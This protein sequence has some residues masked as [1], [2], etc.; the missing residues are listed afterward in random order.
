MDSRSIPELRAWGALNRRREPDSH[1]VALSPAQARSLERLDRTRTLDFARG[2]ILYSVLTAIGAFVLSVR[3]GAP[4]LAILCAIGVGLLVTALG[5]T[6]RL[7]VTVSG[8]VVILT[9]L[10][11]VVALDVGFSGDASF[12]LQLFGLGLAVFVL[13]FEAPRLVRAVLT[14]VIAGMFVALQFLTSD[15]LVT[16]GLS[17]A[18]MHTVSLWNNLLTVSAVLVA[19]LMLQMRF[20]AAR[21]ILEGTA[22]YGELQASTDPLTG[23]VNRRPVVERLTELERESRFDYAIAVLDLDNFKDVNDAFGHDCGDAAIASVAEVLADSF[24]DMDVVS[25]WGGDEFVVVISR[26]LPSELE[27][28]LER[29]RRR[30]ENTWFGC[31]GRDSSVTVSIGAARARPA[32][33]PHDCLTAADE[34]LYQAKEAGRNR[35]VVLHQ[36]DRSVDGRTPQDPLI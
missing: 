30:I 22:R 18:R 24:R 13:L 32:R 34:A 15:A 7:P 14:L 8:V 11:L 26:I 1:P 12:D 6:F 23:L 36:Y 33:T 17:D 19:V 4:A 16:P 5:L 9:N 31:E 20:N 25:R 10:A 35:V 2:Y 27:A 21:R 29:V 3:S 28:L